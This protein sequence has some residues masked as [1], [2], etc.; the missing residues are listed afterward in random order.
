[1]NDRFTEAYAK[2]GKGY[3]G[4]VHLIYTSFKKMLS[5]SNWAQFLILF[6]YYVNSF[7]KIARGSEAPLK[8]R[9]AHS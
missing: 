8:T 3:L 6:L 5:F 9:V 4:P 2:D 1:M 7:L